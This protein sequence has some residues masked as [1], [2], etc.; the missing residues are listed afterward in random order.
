M[1]RQPVG[2]AAVRKRIEPLDRFPPVRQAVRIRVRHQWIR[3][4]SIFLEVGQSIVV[5]I[6]RDVVLQ[7]I[8]TALH[9]PAV[10]NPVG[11]RVVVQ[12]I[13]PMLEFPPVGQSIAIAIPVSVVGQGIQLV[14]RLPA[15]RH[16][17]EVR[18]G[19]ERMGADVFDFFPVSKPVGVGIAHFRMGAIGVFLLVGQAIGI[20]IA[21]GIRRIQGIEQVGTAQFID[22]V[23]AV[24]IG[25]QRLGHV[26]GIDPVKLRVLP[27]QDV[28]VVP[29]LGALHAQYQPCQPPVAHGRGHLNQMVIGFGRRN[30]DLEIEVG[31]MPRDPK[32]RRAAIGTRGN[33]PQADERQSQPRPPRE[34]CFPYIN[35]WQSAPRCRSRPRMVRLTV[36]EHTTP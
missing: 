2:Q 17:V 25:I 24:R 11:I 30:L 22:V 5:R 28:E 1:R 35:R 15:V 19:E 7:R 34:T 29:G 4:A 16:A 18:I 33:Q 26:A 23:D 20:G 32:I 8:E 13:A 3:P 27:H 36:Y 12:G 6:V 31:P 14:C 21:G 9:L 10:R